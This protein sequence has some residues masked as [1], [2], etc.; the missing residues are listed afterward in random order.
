MRLLLVFILLSTLTFHLQSQDEWDTYQTESFEMLYPAHWTLS[1]NVKGCEVVIAL[2]PQEK[3]DEIVTFTLSK[4]KVL[5]EKDDANMEKFQAL[6]FFE[7]EQFLGAEITKQYNDTIN[8]L[9]VVIGEYQYQK[10]KEEYLGKTVLFIKNNMKYKLV[11]RS[12]RRNF[13]AN[14][15]VLNHM[16]NSLKLN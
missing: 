15:V 14:E 4:E 5:D 6:T 12:S 7:I 10:G 1:P 11:I 3:G 2:E 16:I 13:K 9:P 8:E